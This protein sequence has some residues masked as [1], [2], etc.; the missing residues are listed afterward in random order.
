M[1]RTPVFTLFRD[2]LR[3]ADALERSGM[4]LDEAWSRRRFLRTTAA[5]TA[6]LAVPRMAKAQDHARIVILGGG[7]AGLTCA[8]R[9]QQNGVASMILEAAPRAGGRMYSL[10]NYF[11]DGQVAELGGELIDTDHHAIRELARELEVELL[12]LTYLD[13]SN[14]HNFYIDGKLSKSDADWIEPMRPLARAIRAAIGDDGANCDVSDLP[15]Q[16]CWETSRGQR[17]THGI[18][19]NF[20]GGRYGANLGNGTLQTR[21]TEFAAMADRIFPGV[22]KAYTGKAVR[23]HWPTYEWS[24]GSYACYRPGDYQR[25]F[26]ALVEPVG[27][28]VFAGEHTVDE[29]GF[30]NSA[31]ESGNRAAAQVLGMLGLQQVRAA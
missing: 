31:V 3:A 19:T 25:Y 26:R 18:L 4:S 8:Y 1:P 11:P 2:S 12:D 7:T 21:A 20:T 29:F 15:F 17:G 27:K 22:A 16:A 23:Q 14:G 6:A 24:K 13:G 5:A 28:F 30:M 10:Q 9:L